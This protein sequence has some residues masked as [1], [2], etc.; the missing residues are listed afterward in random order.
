M[1]AKELIEDLLFDS[2][3]EDLALEYVE[4]ELGP[5]HI[6]KNFE[7]KFND[8]DIILDIR[9][10]LYNIGADV[11]LASKVANRVI[12]LVVDNTLWIGGGFN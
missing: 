8:K 11:N 9:N 7:N 6:L 12:Q 2:D 4:R 5:Y 3:V 10:W 1:K